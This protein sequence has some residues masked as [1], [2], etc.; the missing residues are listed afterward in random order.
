MYRSY[1]FLKFILHG[2]KLVDRGERTRRQIFWCRL[3][4]GQPTIPGQR[5][6]RGVEPNSGAAGGG[7]I[8]VG[9]A[10]NRRKGHAESVNGYT[11]RWWGEDKIEPYLDTAASVPVFELASLEF[12]RRAHDKGVVYGAGVV[13]KSQRGPTSVTGVGG[14]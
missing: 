1:A 7:G 4:G 3:C 10:G 9:E 6:L 2:P 12:G 11:S 8:E 14:D 13:H 5:L